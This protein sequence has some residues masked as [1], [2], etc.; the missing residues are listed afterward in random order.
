M[1]MQWGVQNYNSIPYT[2]MHCFTDV[3]CYP[4]LNI[5]YVM[6]EPQS[7]LLKFDIG[8]VKDVSVPLC[9]N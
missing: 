5:S 9:L 6:H 1:L 3:C 2:L 7:R 4:F 8:S